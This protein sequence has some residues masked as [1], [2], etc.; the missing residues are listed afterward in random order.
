MAGAIAVATKWQRTVDLH[1]AVLH[2]GT[3]HALLLEVLDAR[4]CQGAVDLETVD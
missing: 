4:P 2:N 1:L 3:D